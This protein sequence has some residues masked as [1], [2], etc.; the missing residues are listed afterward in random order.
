M[1]QVFAMPA[2]GNGPVILAVSVSLLL[3]GVMALLAA[4][5]WASRNT[6]FEVEGGQL[7]ICGDIYGRRIAVAALRLDEAR[8]VDL[9]N[10]R[11]LA[12]G[13][14]RNGSAMPGYQS[15]WFKL[16]NGEKALVFVTDRRRVLYVPT[17]EG[18]SLLLSTPK[19]DALLA[20]LRASR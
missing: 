15:G 6:R 17:K 18:Y 1:R 11:Q 12:P 5:A 3:V 13:F 14:K 10:E 7:R 19:A 16:R 2:A 8:V 9:M 4:F 20:A